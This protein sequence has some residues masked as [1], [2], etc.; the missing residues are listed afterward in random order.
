ML[1]RRNTMTIPRGWAL[2]RAASAFL[3]AATFA[4]TH[5]IPAVRLRATYAVKPT[6]IPGLLS[7]DDQAF[8]NLA[9]PYIAA[10][11]GSVPRPFTNV[12]YP[13]S[14]FPLTGLS[15]P[16]A[17][18]SQTIGRAELAK[19]VTGDPA[20]VIFGYSQGA[21]VVTLYKRDFNALYANPLP[22][23]TIPYP[24]FVVIGNITRPNGGFFARIPGLH[25]SIIGLRLYGATPTETAGAAPGQ[26][27]T[28]DIV[29]Q[30]DGAADFPAYPAN[31][32]ALA[33]AVFGALYVH[34]NYHHLS[35]SDA[36]R[37]RRHGDTAYYMIPAKL[38]PLLEPL[39]RLGVPMPL[40]AALDAPLRVLVE[41]GYDRTASPGQPTPA[42]L[43]PVVKPVALAVNVAR[44]IPTGID[45]GLE[46]LGLGRPFGTTAA[47]PCGVGKPL[48]TPSD[49]ASPMGVSPASSTGNV[50]T[51]LSGA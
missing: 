30:Y 33:N 43:I 1:R 18:Q 51:N 26:V 47:G 19:H 46:Q 36:V 11:V 28:H 20:P 8:E 16:T 3:L 50:S 37:Q 25:I 38:L 10:T 9:E 13:A 35:V 45:D 44:A 5:S 32:F 49:T 27:T 7:I 4:V 23:T 6:Q 41:A 40:L 21:S 22:G 15:S 48:L 12:D 42:R 24:M 29:G 2:V 31:L 14:A 17:D 34:A 39:A